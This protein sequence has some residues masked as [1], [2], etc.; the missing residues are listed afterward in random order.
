[1]IY[2]FNIKED[3]FKELTHLEFP[4]LKYI[5]NFFEEFI[6]ERENLFYFDNREVISNKELS[7][8]INKS[9]ILELQLCLEKKIKPITKLKI[10]EIDIVFTNIK[11]KNLRQRTISTKEILDN[12]TQLVKELRELTPSIW[13]PRKMKNNKDLKNVNIKNN[14]KNTLKRIFKYSDKIYFVDAFLPSH[15]MG[16]NKFFIKSFE[17]S[18]TLF[19]S[20]CHNIDHVEFYNGLTK[21]DLKNKNFRKEKLEEKL[22]EFYKIFNKISANVFIKCGGDAYKTIYHR[23]FISFLDEQNIGIF[24]VDRGLNIIGAD[25]NTTEDRI[26]DSMNVD[27]RNELLEKWSNYV[28]KSSNFIHF[29]TSEIN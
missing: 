13:N 26:I 11:N 29:N 22:K 7:S 17:N 23:M 14:L 15:L 8:G 1:M 18:F 5:I 28:E 21:N 24:K 16:G 9:V 20:L 19:E 6:L 2:S 3:F 25:P 10:P 12:R 27:W 4:D